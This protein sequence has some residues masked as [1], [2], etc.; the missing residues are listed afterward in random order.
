MPPGLLDDVIVLPYND[1]E[2]CRRTVRQH[3]DELACV[4]MEPVSST[5][6][7]LPADPDFLRGMRELTA[8]LG[9]VLIFDE[10]Q[11]LRVAPGGAQEHY[12]VVPDLTAMGK[13]I[14]GGMPAGAFGGRRDIMALFD[15]T[16][17]GAVIGHAGTF[18]A[19]PMTMVAGEATMSQLTPK[20]YD[21]LNGLGEML[22]AKLRAVFDELGVPVQVTGIGSLF[23]I[24]FTSEPITDYRSVLTGNRAM[25][26]ALFMGLLNEGVLV[27]G[28]GGGALNTLTTEEEVDAL[29]DATRRV[30]Q[31]VR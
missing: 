26:K 22:R 18:N 3:R 23:G 27:Q 7:Y 16:G 9:L 24:H 10:V 21:R 28:M 12:D 31:R 15:P 5:F 2:A 11:S 13:I 1:L 17:G 19:N 29:V 20:V 6:G 8:E 30:V 25:N 14:G 4:I